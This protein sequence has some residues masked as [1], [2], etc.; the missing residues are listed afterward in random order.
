MG[1]DRGE[2]GQ[3]RHVVERP[4]AD[5]GHQRALPARAEHADDAVALAQQALGQAAQRLG[6][7]A[8]PVAGA[9]DHAADPRQRP[10]GCDQDRPDDRQHDGHD[11]ADGR[12]LEQVAAHAAADERRDRQ[13]RHR[14]H[15]AER[16]Q[17]DRG[18]RRRH[19]R[20]GHAGL[21]QH[22]ELQRGTHGAAAR[23]DLAH[24]VA[25]QLRQ[26]HGRPALDVQGEP[27]E[28]PQAGQR[29]RLQ[30][31]HRQQPPR[32]QVVELAPGAERLDQARR[33]EVERHARDGEPED[34]AAQLGTAPALGLDRLGPLLDH[35]FEPIA[36]L[37]HRRPAYAHAG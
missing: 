2:R 14:Q 33:H 15:D 31:R 29:A 8:D 22:A 11:D 4:A 20:R 37:G 34:R 23:R 9:L 18:E 3:Q 16:E 35:V 24:G 7:A 6:P 25:G 17:V 32:R 13:H 19:G 10:V 5:G 27:L 12:D 30:R 36:D 21:D 1:A 28:H 26:D